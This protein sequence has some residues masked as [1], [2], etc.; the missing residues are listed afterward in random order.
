M[1]KHHI[2]VC[3]GGDLC[4]LFFSNFSETLCMKVSFDVRISQWEITFSFIFQEFASTCREQPCRACSHALGQF[5]ALGQLTDPGVN[6]ASEH[7]L[8]SVTVHMNLSLPRATLRGGLL[9]VQ[10]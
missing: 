8:T 10:H 7:G 3:T 4:S 6:F 2:N 1:L 5:I 9:I